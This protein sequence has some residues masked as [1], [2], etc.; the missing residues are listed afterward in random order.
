LFALKTTRLTRTSPPFPG[1]IPMAHAAA[2]TAKNAVTAV[3]RVTAR[4]YWAYA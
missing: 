3:A 4:R 2:P 1:S